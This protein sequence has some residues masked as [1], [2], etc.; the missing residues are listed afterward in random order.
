MA[1]AATKAARAPSQ[2][3]ITVRRGQRSASEPNTVPPISV[4]RYVKP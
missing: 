1:I 4:G 2:T 3:I